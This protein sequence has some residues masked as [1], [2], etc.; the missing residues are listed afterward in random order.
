M[1]QKN[2]WR[3]FHEFFCLIIFNF[4]QLR[5]LEPMQKIVIK[6]FKESESKKKKKDKDSGNTFL[7]NVEL[8]LK[9]IHGDWH[10]TWYNVENKAKSCDTDV[11]TLRVRAVYQ[12]V[13][14][15]DLSYYQEL[16]EFLKDDSLLLYQVVEDAILL[17]E[18]VSATFQ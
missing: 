9:D 12:S 17:K 1:R 4:R 3:F 11:C 14:V 18:K 8:S 15:L 2:S 6:I 13:Q 10:E 7:G 16:L 5:E